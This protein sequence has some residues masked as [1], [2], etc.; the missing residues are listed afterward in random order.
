MIAKIPRNNQD[1]W[2]LRSAII[3]LIIRQRCTAQDS[4]QKGIWRVRRFGFAAL[5]L[6]AL[7]WSAITG[8]LHSG[9]EFVGVCLCLFDLHD[10]LVWMCDLCADHSGDFFSADRTRFGQ[11]TGQVIPEM[12]RFTV[13]C[14]SFTSA[15]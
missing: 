12:E 3:Y 6:F 2:L 14:C 5:L 15:V 4:F 1:E 9:D 8:L 10:G 11:L 13:S 7:Q